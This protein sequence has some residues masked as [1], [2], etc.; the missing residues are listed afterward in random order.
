MAFSR[1]YNHRT[2]LG[3]VKSCLYNVQAARMV[4]KTL[5]YVIILPFIPY[6]FAGGLSYRKRHV[7]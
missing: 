4:S 1:F 6:L 5:S 2:V 3:K 7:R